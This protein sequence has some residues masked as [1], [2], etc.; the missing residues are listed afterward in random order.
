MPEYIEDGNYGEGRQPMLLQLWGIPGDPF[1]D[2]AGPSLN[3]L[4]KLMTITLVW[5]HSLFSNR[6]M[7][8]VLGVFVRAD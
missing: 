2:T 1:K 8:E 6:S 5:L 4:I 3:I 7:F